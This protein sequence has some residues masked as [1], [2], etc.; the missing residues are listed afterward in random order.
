MKPLKGASI[1]LF[2]VWATAPFVG[3]DEPVALARQIEPMPWKADWSV[4][5]LSPQKDSRIVIVA[6]YK[7]AGVV[8]EED[9]GYISFFRPQVE[10]EKNGDVITSGPGGEGSL[11]ASGGGDESCEGGG[12]FETLNANGFDYELGLTWQFDGQKQQSF[13]KTFH[14]RWVSQQEFEQDGFK[15]TVKVTVK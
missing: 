10:R 3:A 8:E 2:F 11:W 6:H 9:R 13:K 7:K 4:V 14:C 15:V 1:G 5:Y 12:R